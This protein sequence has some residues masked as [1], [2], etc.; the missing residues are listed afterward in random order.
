MY[1]MLT[2]S[3]FL[4]LK[5]HLTNLA[6]FSSLTLRDAAAV[7]DLHL[8]LDSRL[9]TVQPVDPCLALNQMY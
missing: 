8:D 4:V 2:A 7:I 3:D 9:F 1:F 5:S 6:H